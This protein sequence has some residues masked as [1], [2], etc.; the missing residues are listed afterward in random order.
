MIL[1][2]LNVK[3][4]YKGLYLLLS[5]LTNCPIVNFNTFLNQF[6][7]NKNNKIFIIEENNKIVGYGSLLINYKFYRNCSNVGYIED[8]VVDQKYRGKGYAQLIIN[9]LINYSKEKECYKVILV[10]SDEYLN[11]Y[12]KLGFKIKNNNMILDI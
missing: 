3:D 9:K 11:F 7:K 12:T 6:T 4:Y 10:C 5:Q 1:R 2:E 8:I